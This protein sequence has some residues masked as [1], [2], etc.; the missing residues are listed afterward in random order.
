MAAEQNTGLVVTDIIT[1]QIAIGVQAG[2]KHARPTTVL[3]TK[4]PM[5]QDGP[6][7]KGSNELHC[8]NQSC[9]NVMLLHF[10]A[11]GIFYAYFLPPCSQHCLNFGP[12]PVKIESNHHSG[13]NLAN[14]T[15]R[16]DTI[17]CI[18]SH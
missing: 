1:T 4:L 18:S 17:E 7:K 3:K 5:Q 12:M 14:Q 6:G 15:R 9:V 11:L 13:W 16:N 2:T 8:N 10:E